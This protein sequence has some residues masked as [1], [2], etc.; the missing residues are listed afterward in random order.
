M[1]LVAQ[2]DR[3]LSLK[4]NLYKEVEVVVVVAAEVMTMVLVAAMEAKEV[5]I[6]MDVPHVITAEKKNMYKGTV[7]NF[8]ANSTFCKCC[9]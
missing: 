4:V 1:V 7:G 3:L 8:T 5:E 9:S 6:V 2:T